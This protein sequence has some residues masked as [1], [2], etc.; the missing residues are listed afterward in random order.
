M[1]TKIHIKSNTPIIACKKIALAN[2]NRNTIMSRKITNIKFS[3]LAK[4][5][6]SRSPV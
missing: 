1:A 4:N 3:E 2:I 5:F 6:I